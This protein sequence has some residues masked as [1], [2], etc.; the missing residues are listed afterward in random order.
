MADLVLGGMSAAEAYRRAG[1]KGKNPKVCSAAASRMLSNV[2]IRA[3][4]DAVRKAA[5]EKAAADA[6]LSL[7]EK[8]RFFARIVRTPLLALNEDPADP[9]ADLVKSYKRVDTETG[10][11]V[12]ITMHDALAAIEADNKL[13]GEGQHEADAVFD[14]AKAIA[15]LAGPVLPTD[16]M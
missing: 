9:N 1:F 15:T 16:R 8:R 6:V 12:T 14:L 7:E 4:I 5:G 13:A 3:Y 10:S 2:S 11:T